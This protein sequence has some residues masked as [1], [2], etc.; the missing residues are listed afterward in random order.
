MDNLGPSPLQVK[1]N[2]AVHQAAPVQEAHMWE[3]CVGMVPD[4]LI[5]MQTGRNLGPGPPQVKRCSVQA[6]V[7]EREMN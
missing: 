2:H 4:V 5:V 1:K 7:W 6:H 3:G